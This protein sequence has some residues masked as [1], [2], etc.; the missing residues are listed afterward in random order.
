MEC[1]SAVSQSFKTYVHNH[2]DLSGGPNTSTH[3]DT[4]R[5]PL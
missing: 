4:Q 2:L 3:S 5:Y 1:L